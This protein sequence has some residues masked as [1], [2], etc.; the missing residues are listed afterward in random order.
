MSREKACLFGR[1]K[2]ME[3]DFVKEVER[4]KKLFSVPVDYGKTTKISLK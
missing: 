1:A 3:S 4:R 2:R